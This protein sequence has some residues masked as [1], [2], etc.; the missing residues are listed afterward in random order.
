MMW[1]I[2]MTV[3]LS[4]SPDDGR[5]VA[6]IAVVRADVATPEL[7][8]KLEAGVKSGL[9]HAQ[10]PITKTAAIPGQD[11]ASCETNRACFALIGRAVGAFAV[12]RVEGAV[13]GKEVAVLIQAL[14]STTGQHLGELSFVIPIG[15]V[16]REIPQRMAPLA[17]KLSAMMPSPKPIVIS[18]EPLPPS[19]KL[20]PGESGRPL[21]AVAV[22]PAQG[23]SMA[24]VWV[25]GIGAVVFA[26]ASAGLFG[27]AVSARSCLNGPP[28]NGSPT[29]C[30]P[31][32]Q[33][34]AMASRADV[35]ATTGTIAATIAAGLAVATVVEYLVLKD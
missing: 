2:L 21:E 16:D 31:Q 12:L 23:R 30:V 33:A 8:A 1:S 29:V 5:E 24:P 4:Q 6:V 10:V 11:P 27:M 35:G 3:V 22:V 34:Q 13:I 7:T 14:E 15:D 25:T 28:V 18:P 9:E 17:R 32:T 26:S 20:L 19:S